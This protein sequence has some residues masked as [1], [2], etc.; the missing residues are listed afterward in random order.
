MIVIIS[1]HHTGVIDLLGACCYV[2]CLF[3]EIWFR[4][5]W[6][7]N[8]LLNKQ[9]YEQHWRARLHTYRCLKDKNKICPHNFISNPQQWKPALSYMVKVWC[10]YLEQLID[11]FVRN[12]SKSIIKHFFYV[13][14]INACDVF[15]FTIQFSKQCAMSNIYW[16][17][18]MCRNEV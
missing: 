5:F 10:C 8:T 4:K 18:F 7:K 2:M 1:K 11:W 12:F 14:F 13:L 16:S 3:N 9:T 15:I 6:E 17:D